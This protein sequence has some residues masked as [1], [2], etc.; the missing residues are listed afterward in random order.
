M[1]SQVI[2]RK[3]VAKDLPFIYQF[4][5]Q[6]IEEIEPDNLA[7]WKAARVRIEQSLAGNIERM[8]VAEYQGAPIGHC[9]WSLDEGEPHIF[10]IFVFREHRGKGV[11][12]HLMQHAERDCQEA[13]FTSCWLETHVTNPAKYFFRRSGYEFIESKADWEYYV[14]HFQ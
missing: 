2:I 13:G 6:Y 3:A 9:Y 5:Q 7:K 12:A 1:M 8:F 4:E 14:K 11:A 10:S